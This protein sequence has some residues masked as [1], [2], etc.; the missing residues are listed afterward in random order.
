LLVRQQDLDGGSQQL[1]KAA[2]LAPTNGAIQRLQALTESRRGNLPEAVAHWRKALSLDPQDREAAYALA[3]DLERQGGAANEGDAQR[4]L[5]ELLARGENLAARVEH[6]RIAAKRGD[7]GALT[8]S[9]AALRASAAT[10]SPEAQSQLQALTQAA[11]GDARATGVRVTFLKNVLLREAAYRAALG[12]V[13]IPGSDIG[14]PLTRFLRLENPKP[15]P[16]AADQKLTFAIEP[17]AAGASV[18]ASWAGAMHV[19]EDGAPVIA[20]IGSSGARRWSLR[21]APVQRRNERGRCRSQ[22]RLSH[23]SRARGRRWALC[24]SK[25]ERRPLHRCHR[26]DQALDCHTPDSAPSGV[27]RGLRYGWRSRSRARAARGPTASLAQQ[28]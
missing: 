23:R 18:P 11:S 3:L 14:R 8:K 21:R 15:Q 10:W 20:S 6:A 1:A 16:A 28:Q 27:G 12:D 22:L 5:E 9:L 24:V 7:A 4:V 2:S 25:R 17:V 13:T 19:S 26:G